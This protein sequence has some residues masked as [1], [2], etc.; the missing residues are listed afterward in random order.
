MAEMMQ[1]DVFRKNV[2]AA[3]KEAGLE[4]AEIYTVR[5]DSLRVMAMGGQVADYAVAD[6]LGVSLRGL[7]EGRMGYCSTQAL[8][9]EAIAQLIEG[10]KESAQLCEGEQEE[11][12]YPG[13]ESYAQ[14]ECFAPE[15]EKVTAEEKVALARALEAA[16]A[17][18]DPRLKCN[19]AGVSTSSDEVALE[20][21]FGL[22]LK[23]RDNMIMAHVSVAAREG[24]KV[25]SGHAGRAVRDI[26]EINIDE[27][28]R[29]AGD[30]AIAGLEG[31]P[32]PSG[33][34]D[35]VIK[36][37]TMVDLMSTFCGV[38]SAENAQQGLSLLK[39]KEGTQVAAPCVTIVD[40]PLREGG[41]ATCP[42][43]AE[44]VAAYKKTVIEA[45]RLNTLLHN[46]KTAAKAGV[47]S[48][49]N[50][51][52]ASYA[53]PVKVA[54]TNFYMEAGEMS[55]DAL[56]ETLGDGL[57]ITDVAG[58]HSGANA[59]S[60]DFSL[61][62]SGFIVE[63]GKKGRAV[64]QITVAGNFLKLLESIEAIADDL[65]FPSQ[66]IGCP[67]VLVKGMSIAGK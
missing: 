50:A 51:S 42:F 37:G 3:A 27:L 55:F 52:K 14:A 19:M 44:G 54:P 41:Y 7:F 11:S 15:L 29:E 60:G 9:E 17:P 40:D 35:V 38:F 12:I 47:K 61:L 4:Q 56:L 5:A 43:D 49:G 45:G 46:R 20:N 39:D 6:K 25:A 26:K 59:V 31:A 18:Y 63:G 2:L 16:V 13:D 28:V 21:S 10:V 65:K 24:D 67:S 33:A 8:D 62:C 57:L 48:T 30:E 32:V 34:Y 64:K 23:N 22:Q 53:S 58:L 66:P 1:L 36:N